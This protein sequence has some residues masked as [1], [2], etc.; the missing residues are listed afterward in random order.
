MLDDGALGLGAAVGP[1]D[2]S[3]RRGESEKVEGLLS[4]AAKQVFKQTEPT[5]FHSVRCLLG[6]LGPKGLPE[7]V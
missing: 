1:H 2:V 7:V 3:V 5:C 4:E 6:L